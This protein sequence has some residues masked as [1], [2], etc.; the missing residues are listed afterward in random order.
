MQ[1]KKPSSKREVG[2][3]VSIQDYLIHI[4]G[5]PSAKMN[6]IVVTKTGGRA[7]VS[8]L[9]DDLVEALMLDAERPK[10]GALLELSDS[11]LRLPF[12]ANLFGRTINP[13]GFPLD[14]N[15]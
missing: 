3:V 8:A 6:D 11:G 2:F 1:I 5:L 13:L 10:P 12:Q 7:L 9:N 4:E 15:A 14:G